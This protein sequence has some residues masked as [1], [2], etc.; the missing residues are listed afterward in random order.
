MQMIA[1]SKFQNA[2]RRATATRPFTDK[3]SELVGH[4]AAMAGGD[5]SVSH[6]LLGRAAEQQAGRRLLL[7]LTSNRGLCGGYNANVLRTASANIAD[8]DQLD[9]EVAG[10]KGI[11]YFRFVGRTIARPLTHFAD[12]PTYDQVNH[13]AN[14]YMQWFTDGR[15][16]A[17]D[18]AYM[19]FVSNSKQVPTI[20]RLLPLEPTELADPSEESSHDTQ[21]DF[22]PEPQALLDELL[23]LTVKTRLF[24]FFNEAVVSEQIARMVAMKAATDNAEDMGRRLRRQ[25]N[26]ARQTQI[27]TE[28]NEVVSG[29]EALA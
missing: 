26:R 27:T 6:P 21:Y 29:A 10:R 3:V 2:M 15:Y 17:I 4:L 8:A 11:A 16:D 7:V 14:E 23:P 24:Q 18:V 13:L 22:S 1:T 12:Q 9:L 25:F 5:G 19:R 20:D 28:L